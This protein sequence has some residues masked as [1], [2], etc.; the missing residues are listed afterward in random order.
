MIGRQLLAVSSSC[1][2]LGHATNVDAVC[3]I[4]AVVAWVP[5][6]SALSEAGTSN[7]VQSDAAVVVD[8]IA[9][10]SYVGLPRGSVS[11]PLVARLELLGSV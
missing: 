6:L 1:S 4:R 9:L 2:S 3:A 5:F 11:G 7:M 8:P 10:S